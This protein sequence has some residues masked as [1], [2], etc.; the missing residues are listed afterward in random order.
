MQPAVISPKTA[1]DGG[2]T[3]SRRSDMATPTSAKNRVKSGALIG[4]EHRVR[5]GDLRLGNSE[6]WDSRTFTALHSESKS[7]ILLETAAGSVPRISH[8]ASQ[9]HESPGPTGVQDSLLSVAAAAQELGVCTATVY[10]LSGST[11]RSCRRSF[12]MAP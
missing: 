11:S 8:A 4:A 5:T 10:T 1:T 7:S 9:K 2:L 3:R 12:P 6:G